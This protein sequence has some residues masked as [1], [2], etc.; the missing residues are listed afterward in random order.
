M[1]VPVEERLPY[2]QRGFCQFLL[3]IMFMILC[4]ATIA[5]KIMSKIRIRSRSG[6]HPHC[7]WFPFVE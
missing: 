4:R 7:E 6:T 5:R 3:L 2:E 1:T